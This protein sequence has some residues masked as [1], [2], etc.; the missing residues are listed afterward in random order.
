MTQNLP[1]GAVTSPHAVRLRRMPSA[2]LPRLRP[3]VVLTVLGVAA[4]LAGA[5]A[6]TAPGPV[7][8]RASAASYS[9]GGSALTATAPGVYQGRDGAALV[10]VHT[11]G[12]TLAGAS[13]ALDGAHVTGSCMLPDGARSETCRFTLNGAPLAAVDTWTGGGWHRRYADGRTADIAVAGGRPVPV[14]F[15]VGR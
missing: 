13:A 10:M 3:H 14:P 2:R 4:A 12:E 9:I 15:P 6:S 11:G 5:A 7:A 8:V 1:I